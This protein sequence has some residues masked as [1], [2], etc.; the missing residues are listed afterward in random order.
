MLY[1]KKLEMMKESRLVKVIVDQLGMD[2][3][4]RGGGKSFSC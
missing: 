4:C 1:S 2:G 3:G